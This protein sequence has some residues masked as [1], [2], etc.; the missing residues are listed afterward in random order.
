MQPD[1][2]SKAQ[3]QDV[4][5]AS[6]SGYVE[7]DS[8]ASDALRQ[9]IG[10]VASHLEEFDPFTDPQAF[11]VRRGQRIGEL[12]LAAYVC[13][14][15]DRPEA[16][17]AARDIADLLAR[18]RAR[19]EFADR[20]LRSPAGSSLLSYLHAA[21]RIQ[22]TEDADHA[23]MLQRVVTAGLLQQTESPPYR[24]MDAR[25]G[26][27]WSGLSHDLPSWPD[28]HAAS[29]LAHPVRIPFIEVMGAYAYTHACFFLYGMGTRCP[30]PAFL[31][32]PVA[33]RRTLA[34][35]LVTWCLERDWDLVGEFLLCWECAGLPDTEIS[36]RA[37]D[38]FLRQQKDSGAFP[39]PERR[40]GK[41][42]PGESTDYHA[43]TAFDR[44][45]H[46]TLVAVMALSCR[47]AKHD[48]GPAPPMAA[49]AIVPGNTDPLPLE[50]DL[51]TAV[52]QAQRWLLQV[53]DGVLADDTPRPETLCRLLVSSWICEHL[54]GH[55]PGGIDPL[56]DIAG[57]LARSDAG[58]SAWAAVPPGLRLLSA[59]LLRARGVAMPPLE[60]YFGRVRDVLA[61][62][63][64]EDA[65]D[66]LAL[67]EHRL[68]LAAAAGLPAP[69]RLALE[70]VLSAAGGIQLESESDIDDLAR[71]ISSWAAYGLHPVELPPDAAW[72]VDVLAGAAQHA[73]KA[74]DLSRAASLTRVLSY[75]GD[76]GREA[77]RECCA[78]MLVLQRPSGAFGLS[79]PEVA[80][81]ARSVPGFSATDDLVLP[82]TLD[83][84]WALGEGLGDGW[85]LYGALATECQRGEVV[86]SRMG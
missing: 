61:A 69:P 64:P 45:Y 55:D 42:S 28:L 32:G 72:V 16:H 71:R 51:G 22:G 15:L 27:E 60:A 63:A 6:L 38:A 77:A 78:Y 49:G 74:H 44:Q 84:L 80:G 50:P 1:H 5:P 62:E 76:A 48:A 29:I 81:L 52:A 35:F 23:Q 2:E 7:Q 58:V 17:A 66:D 57:V 83:C 40:G 54:A 75:L 39:G 67:A 8:R 37:W 43:G 82:V 41:P 59:S 18:T 21:L 65:G 46:T 56:A 47:L 24:Q 25:L 79:G 30:V 68:I 31:P 73:L 20:L 36:L 4:A 19:D 3:R 33:T 13:T 14:A 26:L 9:A 53:R 12:A 85:R 34:L 70:E 86:A 11:S 10:W